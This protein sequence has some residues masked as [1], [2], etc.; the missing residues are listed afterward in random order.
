MLFCDDG[1]QLVANTNADDSLE[2]FKEHGTLVEEF[3][4]Q[5]ERDSLVEHSSDES[6]PPAV[7]ASSLREPLHQHHVIMA[8]S[9]MLC[10]CESVDERLSARNTGSNVLL[11]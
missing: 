8:R 6:T 10:S 9:R 2:I 3:A 5:L 4:L 7:A 1:I 11:S